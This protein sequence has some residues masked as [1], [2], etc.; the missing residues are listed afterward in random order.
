MAKVL[1][2]QGAFTPEIYGLPKIHKEGVPLKPIVNT[3]VSTMYELEKYVA[4][5]LNPLV[6]NTNSFIKYSDDFV[7]LIKNERVE[8][9]DILVSFDVV[10]FFTKIL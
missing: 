2:F 3:I 1:I 7:K 5:I 10:S 9:N 4:K 8:S 6:G